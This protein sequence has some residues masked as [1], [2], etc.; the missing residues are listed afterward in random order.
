M[1]NKSWIYIN[2]DWIKVILI[3][4]TTILFNG[5]PLSINPALLE[6]INRNDISSYDNLMNISHLN[7]PSLLEAI[8]LRYN[9][10]QIYT[11]TGKILISIN[12]FQN[13]NLY[14][15][16]L[17]EKYSKNNSLPPHIY[18]LTYY[19]YKNL[20]KFKKNQSILISGESGAGKTYGT[21]EI[22]KYLAYLSKKSKDIAKK[23][24]QANPILEAFGNAKTSRN[25]NSSRF[26]K[27]IKMQFDESYRLIGAKIETYLL[28][29]SRV[30]SNEINF[31]IFYDSSSIK[32]ACDIMNIDY[33]PLL[34]TITAITHLKNIELDHVPN[35]LSCDSNLFYNALNYRYI[36][37]GYESLKLELDSE[38]KINARNSFIMSLYSRLFKYVTK[39]INKCINNPG[40]YFI[41]ILDIFGF[42]SFLDNGFEQFCINYTNEKLQGQFNEYIFYLEQL[43][44]EKEGISWENITYP[45]NKECLDVIEKSVINLL[46]EECKIPKGTDKNFTEKL[47]KLKSPFISSVKTCRYSKFIISHYASN[48]TYNTRNFCNK[49]KDIISNEIQ[50]C[51]NTIPIFSNTYKETSRIRS[52]TLIIQF[53]SQLKNLIKVIKSTTPH[54]IRC[55]KPNDDNIQSNFNRIR[56]NEQIKYSGILAAIKVSRA[57][58]PIRFTY[59]EFY[60]YY[61]IIPKKQIFNLLSENCFCKGKT[62]IFLKNN[63]Y[64]LLEDTKAQILL[65]KVLLIQKNVRCHLQWKKFQ[66]ILSSVLFIQK[67]IRCHLQ[68]R[69]F[70]LIL[71]S[72]LLIQKNIRYHLQWKKFQLI[73]SSILLM[74]KNAKIYLLK[75]RLEYMKNK[76][77]EEESE[78]LKE[79]K[80]IQEESERVKEDTQRLKKEDEKRVQRLKEESER[81]KRERERQDAIIKL[82]EENEKRIREKNLELERERERLKED[83]KLYKRDALRKIKLYEEI[84]KLQEENQKIKYELEQRFSFAKFFKNL[85]KK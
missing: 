53:K 25:D 72:V 11:Y 13:L 4:K 80:R 29:K 14:N 50:L 68:L 69:K 27:F 23:V 48:V 65:D 57:G 63:A 2:N 76:R 42:E 64:Q 56:V 3:N 12:P 15:E 40:K 47:T 1:D 78:R 28:E 85:F 82:Q 21:K 8:H 55:I 43:E 33:T 5:C 59:E 17:M 77:L 58:Y 66:L 30:I 81:L 41:G 62:K 18:Q 60:N 6:P 83:V 51:L 24:I 84:A 44:Y 73:I 10:N 70:Q 37:A 35:L 38:Q 46:D 19:S 7:E 67:N 16:N 75:I 39:Q 74:Q 22:M 36:T 34:N 31:H 61:R 79:N 20:T 52:K 32:K 49:N 54:Y 71:S 45:D 9:K 26:G